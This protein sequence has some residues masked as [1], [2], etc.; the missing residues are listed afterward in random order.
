MLA[1]DLTRID[2]AKKL[3]I[4]IRTLEGRLDKMR[5][6]FDCNKEAGLVALFFRINLIK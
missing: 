4:S 2:I 5:L 6:A 3:G 1:D